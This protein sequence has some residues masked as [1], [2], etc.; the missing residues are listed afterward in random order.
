LAF[1]DSTDALVFLLH[2]EG[3]ALKNKAGK[4][5]G[6]PGQDELPLNLSTE[7]LLRQA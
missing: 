4:P 6:L 2:L 7:T 1:Q 3:E 5:L